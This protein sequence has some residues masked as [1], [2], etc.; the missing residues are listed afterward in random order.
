MKSQ[1]GKM[2]WMNGSMIAAADAACSVVSNGVQLGCGVFETL[3]CVRGSVI[4]LDL[5]FE[6]LE[7]G[8]ERMGYEIPSREILVNAIGEVLEANADLVADLKAESG[9]KVKVRITTMDG[10]CMVEC[11]AMP[12]RGECAKVVV[13]EYVRNERSA[14]AGVKCSLYAENV[15]ALREAQNDGADEVIFLNTQ[16]VVSECAT[17]N[18]FWVKDKVVY[19]PSLVTGCLAGVT[20]ELVCELA[21]SLSLKIQEG[22]YELADLLDADEVFITGTLRGVQGVTH[23]G[24]ADVTDGLGEVTERLRRAY[25]EKYLNA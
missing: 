1:I 12:E 5:H 22:E 3:L 21:A 14:V 15:V 2:V 17:A 11:G 13:S 25:G 24:C 20:R 8:V 6:R 16:G 18:V 23:V 19:T 9:D 10:V 4:G 7:E